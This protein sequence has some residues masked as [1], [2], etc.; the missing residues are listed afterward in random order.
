[1]RETVN[2]LF[3]LGKKAT[4]AAATTRTSTQYCAKST[5]NDIIN[6]LMQLEEMQKRARIHSTGIEATTHSNGLRAL[7]N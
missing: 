1:M 4:T 2:S 3:P 7:E 5:P 6:Y